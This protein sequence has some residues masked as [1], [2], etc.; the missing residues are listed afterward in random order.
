MAFKFIAPTETTPSS[1]DATAL[2]DN[3][4]DFGSVSPLNYAVLKFK[5]GNDN[6]SETTF[7]L[8][9]EGTSYSNGVYLYDEIYFSEDRIGNKGTRASYADISDLD[10]TID[11]VLKPNEV[12][13]TI[14]AIFRCTAD[15]EGGAAEVILKVVES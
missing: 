1:A 7:T 10:Q 6:E 8:S 15:F 5:I 4:L 11:I 3:E 9:A 14:W 2:T 12:S 13:E